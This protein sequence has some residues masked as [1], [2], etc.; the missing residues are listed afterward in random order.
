MRQVIVDASVAKK[1]G[2]LNDDVNACL[3]ACRS[4][5]ASFAQQQP[6]VRHLPPRGRAALLITVSFLT[7]AWATEIRASAEAQHAQLE[8][9]ASSLAASVPSGNGGGARPRQAAHRQISHSPR[10]MTPSFLPN[11]VHFGTRADA[12]KARELYA[13][14]EAGGMKEAKQRLDVLR[15]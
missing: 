10:L 11:G 14:A 3:I 6:S 7:A 8:A 2:I 5:Q 1:I 12:M 4:A 15:R 9:F 13:K